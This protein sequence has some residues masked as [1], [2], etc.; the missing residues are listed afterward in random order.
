MM[1]KIADEKIDVG[2]IQTIG[3]NFKTEAH[4]DKNDTYFQIM[5]VLIN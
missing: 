4:L 1:K 5:E 3:E 2:Y